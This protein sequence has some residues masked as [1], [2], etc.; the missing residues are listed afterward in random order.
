M[1]PAATAARSAGSCSFAMKAPKVFP[2]CP[3]C[4]ATTAS[5]PGCLASQAHDENTPCRR[6]RPDLPGR[7][8]GRRQGA[9][10]PRPSHRSGSREYANGAAPGGSGN[11]GLRG[12]RGDNNPKSWE[13]WPRRRTGRG[14]LPPNHGATERDGVT[15]A[16][17]GYTLGE[18]VRSPRPLCPGIVPGTPT[19][20][21][22]REGP[23]R[24]P[25]S[26][27]SARSHAVPSSCCSRGGVL[28]GWCNG[29][30]RRRPSIRGSGTHRREGSERCRRPALTAPD[31]PGRLSNDTHGRNVVGRPSL[32]AARRV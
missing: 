18:R 28:R 27:W 4:A 3:R 11:A 23:R 29:H 32:L 7:E 5:G 17:G 6:W 12:W 15:A 24:M 26:L 22:V 31:W 19:E 25:A 8:S 13:S 1:S 14:G 9:W 30:A 10:P 21:S 20:D 2:G 16:S